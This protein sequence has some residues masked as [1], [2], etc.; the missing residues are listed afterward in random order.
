MNNLA[1]AM[2]VAREIYNKGSIE[3]QRE[4]TKLISGN[5]RP[6]RVILNPRTKEGRNNG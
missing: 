6:E 1:K 3:Q 4:Y 5:E 2:G